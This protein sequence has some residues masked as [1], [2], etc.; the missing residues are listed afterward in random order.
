LNFNS[1]I[2]PGKPK[3]QLSNNAEYLKIKGIVSSNNLH[4]ICSSGNCP[5][6]SECWGNGTATFMILGNICTRSCRFCSVPSGKP[7]NPDAEEINNLSEAVSLM[8]LKHCVITSV[9][10]DDL[11]DKGSGFWAECIENIKMKNPGVT[12]EALIP[13]FYGVKENIMKVTDTKPEIISHNIE[14]VRRL[15]R[16]IRN[17]AIYERSLDVIKLISDSGIISKSGLMVGL[18]ENENEI[19]ETMDDLL[20]SG[21]K[22]L[23]IGQYLQPAK[24][25]YPVKKYYSDK[26]FEKFKQIGL[27]KGFKIVESKKLIR[28]SFNAEKHI[29]IKN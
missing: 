9:D 16:T 14:T 8:K 20:L 3:I 26:D 19:F 7:L 13:D 1:K 15:T 4:T 6:I 2:N 29:T 28:T 23:T 18:G 5:N 21:C 11:P 17:L 25:N 27:Q 24:E 10:R 22:I 12:I